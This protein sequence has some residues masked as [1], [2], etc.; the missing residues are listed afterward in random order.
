MHSLKAAPADRKQAEH[1]VNELIK[2][3]NTYSNPA[4]APS[5]NDLGQFLADNL[6]VTNN[7][8]QV[9]HDLNSLIMHIRELQQQ[10]SN[11]TYT[12]QQDSL[13][14]DGNKLALRYNIDLTSKAGKRTEFQIFA[15]LTFEDGKV[16][17]I[18]Q[19]LH[20]KGSNT[21]NQH[22]SHNQNHSHNQ[23]SHNQDHCNHKHSK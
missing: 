13:V 21:Y 15:N 6:T 12:K 16:S 14:F 4:H 18:E 3:F 2:Q 17:K 5:H 8:Q 19:V 20:E 7:D 23:N 22:N 1:I 11:A 9:S 10:F